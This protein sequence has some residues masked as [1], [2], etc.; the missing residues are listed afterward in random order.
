MKRYKPA[1]TNTQK[2]WPNLDVK[3]LEASMVECEGGEYIKY[4]PMHEAAPKMYAMLERLLQPYG[5]EDIS[6]EEVSNLLAEARGEL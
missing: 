2:P 4:S 5:F 3:I 1:L 6:E